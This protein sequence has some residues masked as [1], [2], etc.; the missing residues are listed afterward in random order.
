MTQIFAMLL[1]VSDA[2]SCKILRIWLTLRRFY[3][4][5]LFM[6]RPLVLIY[7]LVLWFIYKPVFVF[8]LLMTTSASNIFC[9]YRAFKILN[10]CEAYEVYLFGKGYFMDNR[11]VR[12]YKG[13]ATCGRKTKYK[14]CTTL[15]NLKK[16]GKWHLD[17][18]IFTSMESRFRNLSFPNLIK[19]YIYSTHS[20]FYFKD[21]M[22]EPFYYTRLYITG[23]NVLE[24]LEVQTSSMWNLKPVY[25][26][27]NR[28][29][30][31][32]LHIL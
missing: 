14:Y 18:N 13:F 20:K 15:C 22:Y 4:P 9:L 26:S 3:W 7:E 1:S 10:S 32:S 27:D 21:F 29:R 24:N 5:L 17:N 25:H 16:P 31:F 23:K 19:V 8:A 6:Q 2:L 28:Q 12:I 11:S 30:N